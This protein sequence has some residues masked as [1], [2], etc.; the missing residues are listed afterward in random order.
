MQ[1]LQTLYQLF[2]VD[3]GENYVRQRQIDGALVP[4]HPLQVSD[5]SDIVIIGDSLAEINA[6]LKIGDSRERTAASA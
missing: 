6:R 1:G 5:L 4:R 3:A 2:A